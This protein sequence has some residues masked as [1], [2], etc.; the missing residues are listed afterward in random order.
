ML[1][2]RIINQGTINE[3]G[4]KPDPQFALPSTVNWMRALRIL[5][6][7]QGIN[8]GTAASFYS[9]QGKR[10]MGTLEENTVLEQL[11]LGLHHLSAIQQFRGGATSADY[12]RVGILAWY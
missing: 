12:S 8:F 3:P 2:D 1:Y 10:R 5:I 4:G 11:F 9:M 7:Y 6:E